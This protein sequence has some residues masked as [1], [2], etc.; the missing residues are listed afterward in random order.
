MNE[1]VE[2]LGRIADSLERIEVVVCGQEFDDLGLGEFVRFMRMRMGITQTELAARAKLSRETIRKAENG[3]GQAS[4]YTLHRI[5]IALGVDKLEIMKR[6]CS[7][8][9]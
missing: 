4:T 2:Q 6:Q 3:I 5:A 9:T 8:E 1:I 7:N